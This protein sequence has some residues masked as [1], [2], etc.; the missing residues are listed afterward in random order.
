ME[1]KIDMDRVSVT[2]EFSY[3]GTVDFEETVQHFKYNG[4]PYR[5]E[6]TLGY[7]V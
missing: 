3:R 6:S 2:D 7:E 4:V 5:Y 1:D